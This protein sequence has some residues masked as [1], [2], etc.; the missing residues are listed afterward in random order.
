MHADESDERPDKSTEV[1][2]ENRDVIRPV[3]DV[4]SLVCHAHLAMAIRCL[5]SFARCYA[6]AHTLTVHDDGSL[7]E[8]DCDL[9]RE[10]LHGV[11]IVSRAQ[12][13][14]LIWPRLKNHPQCE[15]FRRD[16]VFGPKLIDIPL[17]CP[18]GYAYVD[19]DILFQRRF[20]GFEA[21]APIVY[22]LDVHEAYSLTFRQR[23]LERPRL[24]LPDRVNAGLMYVDGGAFDLD[25]IEWFLGLHPYHSQPFL[26]EQTAWAAMCARLDAR[27]WNPAQVNFP[28]QTAGDQD[29]V[30]LHFITPLRGALATTQ[31]THPNA[32]E[33]PRRLTTLPATYTSLPGALFRRTIERARA[34]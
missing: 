4:R 5:A 24:R 25:C 29:R 27:Y 31:D 19:H 14:E 20:T 30:A 34:G 8:R 12:A 3:L 13:D 32:T 23:Y 18:G 22:M 17:L 28:T 21:D 10:K 11:R 7:T 2:P 26:V 1:A 33:P 6:E 16:V 15:A 9:L